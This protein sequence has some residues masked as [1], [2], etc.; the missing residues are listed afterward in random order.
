MQ[1]ITGVCRRSRFMRQ[2]VCDGVEVGGRRPLSHVMYRHVYPSQQYT[3]SRDVLGDGNNYFAHG[4]VA[5]YCNEGLCVC[6]S[7]C[8][9]VRLSARLSQEP[10]SQTSLVFLRVLSMTVVPS[11]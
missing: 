8:L 7:V 1:S 5:E 9:S 11:S 4:R 10:L 6:V 3:G 2:N